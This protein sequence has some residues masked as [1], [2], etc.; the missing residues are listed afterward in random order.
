[1]RRSGEE[2]N[3]EEIERFLI[4]MEKRELSRAST[5][6]AELDKTLGGGFIRGSLVLVSGPP[7]SG[8][9]TLALQFVFSSKAEKALYITFTEPVEKIREFFKTYSFYDEERVLSKEI[10]F[11]DFD[12]LRSILEE[13]A[14]RKFDKMLI[15]ILSDFIKKSNVRKVVIDSIT[16]LK[17]YFDSRSDYREFLMRLS[18]LAFETK[19]V[20]LMT[21]EVET[22]GSELIPRYDFESYVADVIILLSMEVSPVGVSRWLQVL[23]A[24]GTMYSDV[25]RSF[26]ITGDGIIFI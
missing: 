3:I 25:R 1:M 22:R 15:Q 13:S 19:A 23:K 9:T 26:R 20:I 14:I 16:S 5:G 10:M 17:E 24:R 4:E 18:K 8:K 21:S 6:I 12:I 7:G 2:I 11:M